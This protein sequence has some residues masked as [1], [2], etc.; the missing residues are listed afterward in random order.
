VRKE[1]ILLLLAA[2][3]F[4]QSAVPSAYFESPEIRDEKFVLWHDPGAVES[5]DF[6]YGIGGPDM[7]PEPPF[8]FVR[9]DE[10]GTD[11]KVAVK[12]AK[13]R[14]WVI[15][16]GVEA[17]PDTFG[18]RLAWALGYY[19]EPTYFVPQ[20]TIQGV[21]GLKRAN[22][23]VNR[24]GQFQNGRFQNRS[25]E[26]KFL[27]WVNWSWD[28][29]P[30][31]GTPELGGLKIVMM[32]LSNWDNKDSRDADSR[33]TNTAIYQVDDR[34]FYFIDDWGGAMGHWGKLLTRSKWD[35]KSFYDQSPK[36]ISSGHD[37][38]QWGYSGQ[39]TNLLTK[40]IGPRDIAWVL[41]YLGRVTDEQLRAGLLSSGASEEEARYYA[42]GL[43][44]RIREMQQI[45]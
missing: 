14:Q 42:G 11:A 36:F 41:Q 19:V 31:V 37:G 33:G 22:S 21:H 1:T 44:L 45:P 2:C 5:L 12:D 25:K 8:T 10:S 43:R 18:T 9:E 20:G 39:H 6:R 15:K 29:N 16:F 4:A 32:L 34:Y 40:G 30:F 24:Q 13:D 28:D 35:A 17:S 27:K 3:G 23:Y 26:P 38:I 7:Q